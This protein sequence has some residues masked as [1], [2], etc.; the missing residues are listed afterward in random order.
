MTWHDERGAQ[1]VPLPHEE[2]PF[3]KAFITV[4]G[5]WMEEGS[6][7]KSTK[8][9]TND[10]IA[11][12]YWSFSLDFLFSFHSAHHPLFSEKP[13]R[14]VC[15]W[16][17]LHCFVVPCTIFFACLLANWVSDV[18]S[19][20]KSPLCQKKIP[21]KSVSLPPSRG[22]E[23][24]WPREALAWETCVFDTKFY[25][26]HFSSEARIRRRLPSRTEW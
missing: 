16:Q 23:T 3:V 12:L 7:L 9:D 15:T 19:N 6:L 2:K 1:V 8:G 22:V 21:E 5:F 11:I 20:W 24:F 4:K 13:C 17:I 26:P 18:W 10:F 25:K 14:N